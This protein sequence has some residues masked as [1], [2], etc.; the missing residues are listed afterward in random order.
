[1]FSMTLVSTNSNGR[2]KI[3][4]L[5]ALENQPQVKLDQSWP[6]LIKISNKLG[7]DVKTWKMLFRYGFD[8]LLHLVN[9]GLTRG[10][11]VSL[12]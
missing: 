10:I 3:I 1:M 4:F 8:Q 12:T 7:V 6:K 9:L 5:I 2:I 11:L